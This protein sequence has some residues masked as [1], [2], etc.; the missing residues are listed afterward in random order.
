VSFVNGLYYIP[1]AS[2]TFT[3]IITDPDRST[4]SYGFEMSAR[5][6]TDLVNGQAGDFIA[7]ASQQVICDDGSIK[8]STGCPAAYPVEFIEQS[9]PLGVGQG[10]RIQVTWTPPVT[11]VGNVHIYVAAVSKDGDGPEAKT[12]TASYI[13]APATSTS[14]RIIPHIADGSGFRTTNILLNTGTQAANFTINY[15]GDQGGSLLLPF[16]G[17]DGTTAVLSGV[18]PAGGARFI[19][20]AGAGTELH[21]G[22]AEL[23]APSTVDGN[24]VFGFQ[25]SGQG[26]SEAAVPLSSAGGKEWYVP[27][28]NTA[29][30]VTSIAFANP[31]QQDAAVSAVIVTTQ[32]PNDKPDE[33]TGLKNRLGALPTTE[34]KIHKPAHQG[35]R[36]IHPTGTIHVPAHGHYSEVLS[37]S[38]PSTQQQRGVVHFSSNTDV[39]AL[40][41]RANGKALTTFEPLSA[42]ATTA[43]TI[44]HIADGGGWKM[45]FLLVNT[46]TQDGQFTLT[47]WGDDGSMLSLPLGADG[48]VASL[49]GKIS[50]GG[51]RIVQT[52]GTNAQLATGWAELAVTG[53]IGGT[54]ILALQMPGQPDSEFA[55]PFAT[56]A[57][58]H[59]YIPYDYTPGYST[60][61]ALT[62]PDPGKVANVTFP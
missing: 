7:G 43:Q 52:T 55:A 58:T 29:A 47:F 15:W 40:V 49:T 36:P 6:E 10:N 2:Q 41:I 38:L 57:S 25:S 51:L 32:G 50:P 3:I 5:L 4:A 54:A 27:F 56:G 19:Q 11:N 17:A 23:I 16:T 46:G 60:G 48:T 34:Q 30:Y 24:S 18:I 61:V 12:Y 22:W 35:R 28:D 21:Q 14:T 20:T 39:F 62:N 42:V 59:L 31:G 33:L 1:G 53:A 9:A 8:G 26:D 37:A 13:L 45:T 44:P